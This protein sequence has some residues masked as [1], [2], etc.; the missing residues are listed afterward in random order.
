MTSR[1]AVLGSPIAHSRS[2]LLHA[3]A[4]GVLGLDWRYDRVKATEE[5][6]PVRLSGLALDRADHTGP[7]WVARRAGANGVV[8]VN[9][10]Q[11]CLGAAA[12]SR[13]IDVH[14]V[15]EVMQFYDGAELLKTAV[16]QRTGP[17]R[18]RRASI[19]G[20]RSKLKKSVTDQ[21]K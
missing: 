12:A 19:P 8:S 1:L 7:E 15:G 20:S 10:Q 9:W 16:R 6:L 11:V 5:S 21:P 3:A 4:A 18:K 2:P 14:I 13:N 17:V